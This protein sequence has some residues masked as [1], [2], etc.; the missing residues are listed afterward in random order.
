MTVSKDLVLCVCVGACVKEG[1]GEGRGD[2]EMTP[3]PP[4][5]G[6]RW[7]STSLYSSGPT[8][9][10]SY[11]NCHLH[12]PS[13]Y[14]PRNTRALHLEQTS[15]AREPDCPLDQHLGTPASCCSDSLELFR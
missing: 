2:R 6:A 1:G 5:E 8:M 7:I 10:N 14:K 13:S 12:I 15:T 11:D 9:G 4:L 3:H